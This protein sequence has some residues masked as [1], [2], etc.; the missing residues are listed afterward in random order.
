MASAAQRYCDL[1]MKGGITSGIVYPAAVLELAKQFRFKN[2]GGTSAGAIAAAATAAAAVGDRSGLRQPPAAPSHPADKIGFKGLEAVAASLASEGFICGLFQPAP[3]ARRAYRTLVAL[4]GDKAKPL[5]LAHALFAAVAIAPVE[6]LLIAG[7]LMGFAWWWA[8]APGMI[9]AAAPT[10][11]CAYLAAAVFALMRV[12]RA[13]RRNFLGLCSGRSRPKWFAKWRKPA[14]PALTEWLHTILQQ[15]ADKPLDQPLT[16]ADLKNAARYPGEP[17]T[18]HALTLSMI[19]TCVS[20]HEPRTLPFAEGNF[21]F[22]EE[23]FAALFPDELVKWLVAKAPDRRVFAGATY[24]ELP[25][26]DALP[27]LV[28]T[29][30]SLSFPLLISAVPLHELDHRKSEAATPDQAFRA[31]WFSDGGIS[32]N[33]PIHLF[34]APLPLWPTFA[35]N[36]VYQET[37]QSTPDKAVWLPT[38]NNK[39]WQRKYHAF[40]ARLA[41]GEL[42]RFLGAIVETMQNWRDLIQARAPGYRD[43]IVHVALT[44][45]EGGMN[46]AMPGKVLK[47]ISEKGAR[48]GT[49]LATEFR[50]DNHLWLRWRNLADALQRY[51]IRFGSDTGLQAAIPAYQSAYGLPKGEG[52]PP[53]YKFRTAEARAKAAELY[54]LLQAQGAEWDDLWPDLGIGAPR[55]AVHFRIDPIY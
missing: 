19:T 41:L 22:R 27:V 50:F 33:F 48:A 12:A 39:G 18:A 44:P 10:L 8:A 52:E 36:L 51:V 4:T 5:K 46:I 45:K 35:I 17:A 21:W 11:V 23:E 31:C 37:A 53:S 15:L 20:H 30:M 7:L 24:Y 25:R 29:R 42:G 55:P 47:Q 43:R 2:I 28:G 26:K 34:D 9:A 1:V 6:F 40:S 32:S 3:G 16:F 14:K 13:A 54:A 38:G 49:L